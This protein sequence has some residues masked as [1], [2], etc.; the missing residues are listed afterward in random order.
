[1]A[2]AEAVPHFVHDYV[3]QKHKVACAV[4][5]VFRA[6]ERHVA[7]VGEVVVRQHVVQPVDREAH[8]AHVAARPELPGRIRPRPAVI[9]DFDVRDSRYRRPVRHDVGEQGL[10]GVARTELRIERR[11]NQ[12]RSARVAGIVVRRKRIGQSDRLSVAEHRPVGGRLGPAV[13]AVVGVRIGRRM[14]Q[15]LELFHVPLRRP[16]CVA[17]ADAGGRPKPS[18]GRKGAVAAVEAIRERIG[19]RLRREHDARDDEHRSKPV[20]SGHGDPRQGHC[21]TCPALHRAFKYRPPKALQKCDGAE[22]CESIGLN[23]LGD[24]ARRVGRAV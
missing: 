5:P 3:S 9:A 22:R 11:V 4:S 12:V 14:D 8:D 17:G 7:A 20:R 13:A 10:P 16:R 1:M 21:C 19:V 2:Q 6:V 15:A 24:A 18:R 23:A